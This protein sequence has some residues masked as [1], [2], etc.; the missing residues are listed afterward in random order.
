LAGHAHIGLSDSRIAV[1]DLDGGVG[2]QKVELGAR[3]AYEQFFVL[4]RGC[5]LLGHLGFWFQISGADGAVR[6]FQSGS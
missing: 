6:G 1:G 3:T 5:G 4:V 2:V